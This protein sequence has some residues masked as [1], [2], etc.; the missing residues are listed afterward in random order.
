MKNITH[1]HS[2][3]LS[4]KYHSVKKS[5]YTW[6]WTCNIRRFVR[7]SGKGGRHGPRP[8]PRIY[9]SVCV[10]VRAGD[11]PHEACGLEVPALADRGGELVNSGGEVVIVDLTIYVLPLHRD[12]CISNERVWSGEFNWLPITLYIV[13][14]KSLSLFIHMYIM[15]YVKMLGF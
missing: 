13:L 6:H 5:L 14:L 1:D 10:S 15:Y 9:A 7:S 8:P 12:T 2:N 11:A 4:L 3:K